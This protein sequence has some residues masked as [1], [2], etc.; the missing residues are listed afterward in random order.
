MELDNYNEFLQC[1]KVMN[2]ENNKKQSNTI[3]ILVQRL[4]LKEIELVQS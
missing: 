4:R 3:S 2:K 1:I